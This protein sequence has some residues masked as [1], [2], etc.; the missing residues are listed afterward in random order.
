[1]QRTTSQ[2]WLRLV[3]CGLGLAAALCATGCQIS[4]GGMTHPSPF[5]LTDDVQY[6]APGSEFK[7]AKEAAAMKAYAAE[8]KLQ[9]N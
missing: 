5:Y 2:T 3:F 7:L 4:A 6:F 9:G 1:M 8:Q